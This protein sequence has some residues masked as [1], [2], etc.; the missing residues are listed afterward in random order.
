M[1]YSFIFRGKNTKNLSE[2]YWF[3]L[4]KKRTLELSGFRLGVFLCGEDTAQGNI[5]LVLC[6]HKTILAKILTAPKSNPKKIY[7]CTR[8]RQIALKSKR[9]YF[10]VIIMAFLGIFLVEYLQPKP[11][12]WK[13]TYSKSDKIP[14]GNYILFDRL[15]DIFNVSEA[16]TSYTTLFELDRNEHTE[17]YNLIFINEDFD[18]DKID[19]EIIL[20]MAEEGHHFFI[21]AHEFG[22]KFAD[23]LGI[24]INFDH[25]Y[26]FASDDSIQTDSLSLSFHDPKLTLSKPCFYRV[27]SAPFY[28]VPDSMPTAEVLGSNS[29]HKPTFLRIPRGEGVIYLSTTPLA[30]T[31]YYMLKAHNYEYVAT[32]LSYLPQRSVIWDEYY[33]SGREG[34]R[35][36]F[37]F[38]LSHETL[39]TAWIL[40]LGTV[41]LFMIFRAKRRQRVIPIIKPLQNDSLEFAKTIGRL[42]FHYGDHKNVAVK[43]IAHFQEFTRSRF[44][45]NMQNV[46]EGL[47][48]QLAEKSGVKL[49]AVRQLFQLIAHIQQADEISEAQLIELNRYMEE[50]NR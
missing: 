48:D 39:K 9:T 23:T 5:L 31:N 43:K 47:L 1:A 4:D 8:N 15:S 14:Y 28:F 27:G 21:A 33:K 7:L 50:F 44:H 3:L 35:T 19:I 12:N 18:P 20:K 25:D 30:F 13:Q 26:L 17:L 42:Y 32:A 2:F 45:L 29:N 46:N 38:L 49:S 36:P 10:F 24:K 34:A 22:G 40:L 11:V 37:R 41:L 16:K 6:P